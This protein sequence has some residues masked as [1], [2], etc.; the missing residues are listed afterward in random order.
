LDDAIRHELWLRPD[1]LIEAT[2]LL[3]EVATSPTASRR[4]RRQAMLTLKQHSLDDDSL[5]Q[6]G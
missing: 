5:A 2:K 6:D 3:R 4:I 1:I